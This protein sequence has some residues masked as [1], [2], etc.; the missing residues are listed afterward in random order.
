[1]K[2]KQ[3]K[4]EEYIP[5]KCEIIEIEMEGLICNSITP[6]VNASGEAAWENGGISEGGEMTIGDEGSIAP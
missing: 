1:M 3:T 4:K 5:P 2:R 6:E